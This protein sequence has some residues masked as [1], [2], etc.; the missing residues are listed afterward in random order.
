MEV[1]KILRTSENLN[2][3]RRHQERHI[4]KARF[5]SQRQGLIKREERN[6]LGTHVM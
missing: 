1:H 6:I 2:P 3:L 4:N 5:L